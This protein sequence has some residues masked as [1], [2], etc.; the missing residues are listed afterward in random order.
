MC[1]YTKEQILRASRCQYIRDIAQ[2]LGRVSWI[3][4][5][6]FVRTRL[7]TN[8]LRETDEILRTL[9]IK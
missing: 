8:S 7:V 5:G 3:E 4:A 2:I 6:K 1:K 9:G